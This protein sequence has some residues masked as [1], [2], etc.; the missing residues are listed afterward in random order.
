MIN[1][2]TILQECKE[3]YRAFEKNIVRDRVPKSFEEA[4]VGARKRNPIIAEVKPS[5]PSGMNKI[6]IDP[7]EV[8]LQMIEGGAIGLS[9]LTEKKYF[10]GSLTNLQEVAKVSHVPVLRKDFIFHEAQIPESY[11]YGADS[12]LLISSFF[13]SSK[14]KEFLSKSR[15]LGMEPLVEIHSL[16][17]I[18]KAKEADAR[19]Y[20]IN[21][22]DKDTLEIDIKRSEE[23]SKHIDGLKISASGISTKADL[24]YVLEYCDA[25]LIGNSIMQAEHI[26][27]KTG[28]FV[29]G[30]Q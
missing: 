29:Y 25:A 27:E 19:I 10:S 20:V 12:L 4:I 30:S 13:S 1:F 9:V 21:N 14:L 23:F 16:K 24:E 18:E 17:D 15:E 6:V 3:G 8:G 7:K 26:K 28:E 11:Y 5:S 22:R 2:E